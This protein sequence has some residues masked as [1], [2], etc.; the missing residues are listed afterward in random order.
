[1]QSLK[2]ILVADVDPVT[3]KP[4]ARFDISC[5][6]ASKILILYNRRLN[7]TWLERSVVVSQVFRDEEDYFV[8]ALSLRLFLGDDRILCNRTYNLNDPG[9]NSVWL[10]QNGQ[11][12]PSEVMRK[13][14]GFPNR[15]QQILP[16]KALSRLLLQNEM[17]E[18]MRDVWMDL[19]KSIEDPRILTW[20]VDKTLY[21][22]HTQPHRPDAERGTV[23]ITEYCPHF[24]QD[25]VPTNN[26]HRSADPDQEA[27]PV[28]REE[29]GSDRPRKRKW[30]WADE[31]EC[32]GWDMMTF[33][34]SLNLSSEQTLQLVLQLNQQREVTN[35]TVHRQEQEQETVRHVTV[36]RDK[37]LTTRIANEQHQK[38]LQAA[39]LFHEKTVRLE[40]RERERTKRRRLN[41]GIRVEVAASQDCKCNV[42]SEKLSRDFEIDH[43]I[44]LASNG[45]DELENMQALCR[46]CHGKKTWR[47]NATR[48]GQPLYERSSADA[49]TQARM[50][51]CG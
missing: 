1:M 15:P 36:A 46:G 51:C 25:T 39:N 10:R 7:G 16:V 12:P 45:R 2:N 9:H 21:I 23:P 31:G 32:R 6:D 40:T 17:G 18:L 41:A 8:L 44:P 19:L 38:T 24:D 34:P 33:I 14:C 27:E 5:N 11:Q 42:C 20:L 28:D 29:T 4:H 48:F 37:E 50:C 35:Q 49:S 3:R 22:T 26:Q 30:G 47:E 13:Q 43:I